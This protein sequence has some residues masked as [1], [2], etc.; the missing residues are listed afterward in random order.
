MHQK[1][2]LEGRSVRKY[3]WKPLYF[4]CPERIFFC[5]NCSRILRSGRGALAHEPRHRYRGRLARSV[6]L[7]GGSVPPPPC[8]IMNSCDPAVMSVVAVVTVSL[9]LEASPLLPARCGPSG[10]IAVCSC[11][12][13]DPA[14]STPT[15]PRGIPAKT[16][17]SGPRLLFVFPGGSPISLRCLRQ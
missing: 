2:R 12:S 1:A 10:D 5:H 3:K 4:C 15:L 7:Q 6:S 17:M 8:N 13:P 9:A 11:S 14:N 16:S